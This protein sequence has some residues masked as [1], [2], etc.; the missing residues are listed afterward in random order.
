MNV[1]RSVDA[2]LKSGRYN[3]DDRARP[4]STSGRRRAVAAADM[5][6]FYLDLEDGGTFPVVVG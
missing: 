1:C 2:E 5:G 6:I 3:E 4:G